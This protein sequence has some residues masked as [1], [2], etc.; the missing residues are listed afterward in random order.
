MSPSSRDWRLYADDI[1]EAC[2]KIRRFTTGMSFPNF[3]A[4]ER[5]RDAVIRNLEVIG[6]AAKNLPD[7]VIAR[8]PE[9]EWRKIRGMRDV[10]AHGYFGMDARVVWST[11]TT[12]LETLQTAVR[13]LLG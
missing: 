6:E 13:G 8:A 7:D 9:I 10:L 12:K 11:V 1:I 4:D 5:T 2:E 3:L